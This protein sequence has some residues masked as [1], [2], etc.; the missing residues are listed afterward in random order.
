VVRERRQL[1]LRLLELTE[2]C[3]CFPLPLRPSSTAATVTI[4]TSCSSLITS[5]LEKLC[6][7]GY[8]NG[9]TIYK[10]RNRRTSLIYAL[11]L[12]RGDSDPLICLQIL[13]EMEILR[14]TD[15]P[16]IVKSHDKHETSER[17]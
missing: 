9:G 4:A 7:L 3:P 17:L 14:R 10:V 6:V 8:G 13:H 5:D 12:V 15:S 11:K 16:H 1:N 2:R